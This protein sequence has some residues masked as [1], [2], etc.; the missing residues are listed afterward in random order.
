MAERRQS[1]E[2]A[3]GKEEGRKTG[4]GG[5]RKREREPEREKKVEEVRGPGEGG[6]ST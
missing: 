5:G 3:R 2:E 4:V 6:G 1:P